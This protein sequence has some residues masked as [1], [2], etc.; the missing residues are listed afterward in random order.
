MGE[1][2]YKR[3]DRQDINFQ[4]IKSDHTAQHQENKQPNQHVGRR[5]K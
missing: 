4:N 2:I 5:P 3:S 1:N